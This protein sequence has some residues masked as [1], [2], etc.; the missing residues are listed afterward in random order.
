MSIKILD[1]NGRIKSNSVLVYSSEF[2]SLKGKILDFV[3]WS[4]TKSGS[5]LEMWC[6]PLFLTYTFLLITALNS[7]L[8]WSSFKIFPVS[9]T[10]VCKF[11]FPSPRLSLHLDLSVLGGVR[12]QSSDLSLSSGSPDWH[13]WEE[14]P[15]FLLLPSQQ[16]L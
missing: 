1:L 8:F 7:D 14:L 16:F 15:F 3:K 12:G 6:S 11:Y 9:Q 10:S 2:D 5:A 13:K 4:K